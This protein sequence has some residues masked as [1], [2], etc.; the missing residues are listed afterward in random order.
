MS[1]LD[2]LWRKKR[3][4]P[5]VRQNYCD[6]NKVYFILFYYFEEHNNVYY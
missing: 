6:S 1:G 3:L 4:I 5:G 2:V